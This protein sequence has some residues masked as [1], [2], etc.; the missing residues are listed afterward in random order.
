MEQNATV[1]SLPIT[2]FAEER[3]KELGEKLDWLGGSVVNFHDGTWGIYLS[4]RLRI[5]LAGGRHRKPVESHTVVTA[6]E[7]IKGTSLIDLINHRY[8]ESKEF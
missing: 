6:E 8:T 5:R 2:E 1:T 3:A 7:L 4:P